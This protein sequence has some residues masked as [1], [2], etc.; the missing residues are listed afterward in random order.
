MGELIFYL[1][2]RFIPQSQA[3]ISVT[4]LGFV[5]GY[6]VF[7]FLRTYHGCPFKLDEHLDRLANSAREIHLTLLWSK[8]KLHDLVLATIS[9][10]HLPEANIKII[11]SGGESSDQ[12]TPGDKPTLAILVYPPVVY[13]KPFYDNGIKV[14][15]V[16]VLRS[17]PLAK[18]INYIPA[19]VALAQAAEHKAVEALYVNSRHEVLEGT[20]TN[21][22]VFRGD[23]LITPK[24]GVLLG[25]T[26]KVVLELAKKE[27]KIKL[28]AI[29]Y[30]ELKA[31][32][33]AF[34]TASNK[35]VMP[36]VQID[37]IKVGNGKVGQRTRR[38]MELF[39][40]YTYGRH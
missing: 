4:D 24:D 29:K 3:K 7:D 28:R 34:I 37:G 39:K 10:N 2:G 33:E 25:I 12:L 35:E 26:R 8:R 22:F 20:T 5:R 19:I 17:F 11:V 38:I 6:G 15:T 31:V 14:I 36:V 13:P 16:S 27:F 30:K 1:N 21:F 18:T 40:D 23:T 9:K 32:D